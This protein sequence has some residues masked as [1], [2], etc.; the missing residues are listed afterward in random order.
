MRATVPTPDNRM[1][2]LGTIVGAFLLALTAVRADE[3]T[4]ESSS[5]GTATA[6]KTKTCFACN[7]TAIS[8]CTAASCANGQ[9]D[10]PGPCLKLSKGV[11]IRRNTGDPDVLWQAVKRGNRT[12]FFSSSHV[13]SYYTFDAAGNPVENKCPVCD[14]TT[15]V[16]CNECAGKGALACRICD[17]KK[18][19]P[20][21]WT[22]FDNPRLKDRPTR[23]RLKDGRVLVGRKVM[24]V[25]S[26]LVI[27]TEQGDEKVRESE[28]VAEE[29]PSA[30]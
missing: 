15:R 23:Y 11:W 9:A 4:R 22:A 26:T 29:K 30:K 24:T 2:L 28:V 12:W 13:G 14:G 17:G 8:K 7:G 16:T 10:C 18:V 5:P 25:G 6:E 3:T 21:Y 27:R 1:N 20:E 19:V